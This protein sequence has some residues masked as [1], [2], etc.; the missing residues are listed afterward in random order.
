MRPGELDDDTLDRAEWVVRIDRREARAFRAEGGIPRSARES[1]LDAQASSVVA[2]ERP[3][4]ADH[5]LIGGL[6]PAYHAR[7]HG[8]GDEV[9]SVVELSPRGGPSC[10]RPSD[11][12]VIEARPVPEGVPRWR[13]GGRD[14][15]VS[16]LDERQRIGVSEQSLDRSGDPVFFDH[17]AGRR[18]EGPHHVDPEGRVR[19]RIGLEERRGQGTHQSAGTGRTRRGFI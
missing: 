14:L 11:E 5:S 10:P 4:R 13:V 15:G 19:R 2:H 17:R 6:G 18:G 1:D 8:V 12:L 9:V 7:R 3:E 16:R